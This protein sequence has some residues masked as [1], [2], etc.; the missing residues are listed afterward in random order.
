MCLLHVVDEVVETAE[1]KTAAIEVALVGV[2]DDCCN[3]YALLSCSQ[4]RT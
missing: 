2:H 1:V 4:F 3:Y